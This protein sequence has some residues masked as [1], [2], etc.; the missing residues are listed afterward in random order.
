I[1]FPVFSAAI[2]I[3]G[4]AKDRDAR[5]ALGGPITIGG[6]VIHQGDL[7]AGD[8][9]G[10]VRLRADRAEATVEAGHDREAKEADILKRLRAGES[11]LDIY[12]F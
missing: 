2:C 12:G 5:G 10:V 6:V 8:A 7:I 11:T 3:R 1:G 4:T 9:D